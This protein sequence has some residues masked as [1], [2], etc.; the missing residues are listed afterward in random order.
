MVLLAKY[1]RVPGSAPEASL[2][3]ELQQ[4]YVLKR[5]VRRFPSLGVQGAGRQDFERWG[6]HI[7]CL[8]FLFSRDIFLANRGKSLPPELQQ[9]TSKDERRCRALLFENGRCNPPPL[10]RWGV[11]DNGGQQGVFVVLSKTATPFITI[12][13]IVAQR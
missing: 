8:E 12:I 2:L 11:D 9:L 1:Q 5:L 6:C 13:F 7:E 4:L 3:R 10:C